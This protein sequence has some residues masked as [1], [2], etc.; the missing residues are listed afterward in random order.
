MTVRGKFASHPSFTPDF[1][2]IYD[3]RDITRITLTASEV[4]ALAKDALFGPGSRRAFV[5]P[6]SDTYGAVR[7]FKI[8]REINAGKEEIQIF[9][10]IEDAEAWLSADQVMA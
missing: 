3:G 2:Q 6:H 4:G 1:S 5:A 10:S 8:Y 7:T 9:R